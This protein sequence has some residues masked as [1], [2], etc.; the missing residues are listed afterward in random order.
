MEAAMSADSTF[1]AAFQLDDGPSSE[2]DAQPSR[3]TVD[4]ILNGRRFTVTV[5]SSRRPL[6]ELAQ[7][8]VEIFGDR[9]PR[10]Q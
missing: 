6:E 9:I 3:G 2:A 7:Q 10:L 8:F 1:D 5:S 4:V